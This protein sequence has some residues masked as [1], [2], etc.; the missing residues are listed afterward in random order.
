MFAKLWPKKKSFSG[1]QI[2]FFIFLYILFEYV[3]INRIRMVEN[4]RFWFEKKYKVWKK[5]ERNPSDKIKVF[6]A[7]P[8]LNTFAHTKGNSMKD[9]DLNK[10]HPPAPQLRLS[11]LKHLEIE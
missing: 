8:I 3:H 1:H 9:L 2:F 10:I 7:F 5:L 6:N 11:L 4:L